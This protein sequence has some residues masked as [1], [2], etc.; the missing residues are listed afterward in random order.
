MNLVLRKHGFPRS[1]AVGRTPLNGSLDELFDSM[2]KGYFAPAGAE[3][4]S[5]RNTPRVNVVESDKA[6]VVEA[7]LPGVSKENVKIS[8]DGNKV[9]LEAEVKRETDRSEGE[10]V[11][12]SERSIQKFARSFTLKSDVDDTRTT[13]KLENGILTLTL[14][15]KEELQ[16]KHIPVQ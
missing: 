3:V 10:K 5:A 4:S 8:V 14:P 15:K 11:V 2:V 12:Y 7:E 1:F 13:A 9:T 16:P 6:Y